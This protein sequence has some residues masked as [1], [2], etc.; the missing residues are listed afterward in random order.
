MFVGTRSAEPA[1]S[2]GAEDG[3]ALVEYVLV[4]ALVALAAL[5]ALTVLGDTI[6]G[7]LEFLAGALEAAVPGG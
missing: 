2:L 6:A 5:G 3:Q 7:L 4:L 1:F